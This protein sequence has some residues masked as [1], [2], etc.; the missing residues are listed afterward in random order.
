MMSR[1][2]VTAQRQLIFG[3][4][5]DSL[6]LQTAYAAVD[7]ASAAY[8][9]LD[10]KIRDRFQT[11]MSFVTAMATGELRHFLEEEK[12]KAAIPDPAAVKPADPSIRQVSSDR[13]FL[14]SFEDA[15]GGNKPA[16]P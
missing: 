9:R 7:T 1:F 12:A 16:T 2:G 3:E 10:K 14:T 8:Y 13:S 4:H 6:D 15:S 11:P 5:D